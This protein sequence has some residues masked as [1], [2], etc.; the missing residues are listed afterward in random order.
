[1]N[2]KITIA[3]A[4]SFLLFLS[5]KEGNNNKVTAWESQP[6]SGE[7]G[8]LHAG[9]RQIVSEE[10]GLT[11]MTL[12]IPASEVEYQ[13]AASKNKV[14]F[15]DALRAALRSFMEDSADLE[16]P[17][18]IIQ[19]GYK[20]TSKKEQKEMLFKYMNQQSTSLKLIT[21]NTDVGYP[22]KRESIQEN[23]IFY[24]YIESLSDHLYWA[25]I[26]RSGKRPAYN[27]GFN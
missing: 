26:D 16:S 4:L 21:P 15:E 7:A 12:D 1:M 22:E 5:C 8:K 19:N 2:I 6:K 18:G 27:Y 9:A 25:I 3:C 13:S 24:L 11:N 20:D 17:L 14:S 23:W 10:F